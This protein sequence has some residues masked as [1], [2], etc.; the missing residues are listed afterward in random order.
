MV[1]GRFCLPDEREQLPRPTF[2]S[3]MLLA[4]LVAGGK[5][6]VNTSEAVYIISVKTSRLP[7]LAV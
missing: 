2:G 4:H 7:K 6:Q 5:E 3:Q 1:C